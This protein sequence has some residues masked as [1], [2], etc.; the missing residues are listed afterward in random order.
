MSEYSVEQI[1]AASESVNAA[2]CKSDPLVL[3]PR[4]HKAAELLNAYADLREQIERA[5]EVVSDAHVE[6]IIKSVAHVS[7]DGM[8][9]DSWDRILVRAALES[10]AVAHLLPSGERCP[11]IFPGTHAALCAISIQTK[12]KTS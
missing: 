8:D 7:T 11:E 2:W 1:R 10:K 3:A 12:D 9:G 5:R 6:R 4:C